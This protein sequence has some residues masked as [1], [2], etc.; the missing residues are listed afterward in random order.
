MTAA[1][2]ALAAAGDPTDDVLLGTEQELR[3]LRGQAKRQRSPPH[4]AIKATVL[5][6]SSPLPPPSA[7][8]PSAR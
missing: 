8:T 7:M 4:P 5:P 1:T 2:M 6:Q 3:T